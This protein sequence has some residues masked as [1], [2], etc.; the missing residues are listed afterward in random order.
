MI[1]CLDAGNTRI[2]WGIAATR[3]GGEWLARGAVETA[4]PL[5][6]AAQ[7]DAQPAVRQA[8]ACSVAGPVLETR[9]AALM[10][11]RGVALNW[12]RSSAS[13]QGVVNGYRNP[14]Q[15]GADRWAAL[16]G[17]RELHDGPAVVVMAGTA[18]TIDLLDADGVF[19]GGLILPGFDLMRAALAR[20]TAQLPLAS[21]ALVDLPRSTEEA[22]VAGCLLAQAGAVERFFAR[23]AQDPRARCLVS[24]GAAALLAG[25]LDLPVLRVDNLVLEGL[26]RSA[27]SSTK[28]EME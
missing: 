20:N 23:I 14:A 22:I 1:L 11:T 8:I 27:F 16:I 17:A 18:T 12:L 3:R 7:L 9:L 2:K 21:G 19:R 24:G 5:A 13:A 15:L 10:D 25:A 28:M 4:T 6:L 26:R